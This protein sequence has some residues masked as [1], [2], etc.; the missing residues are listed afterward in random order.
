MPGCSWVS[1]VNGTGET[2]LVVVNK[3]RIR[4]DNITIVWREITEEASD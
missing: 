3:S 1:A 4:K 2:G